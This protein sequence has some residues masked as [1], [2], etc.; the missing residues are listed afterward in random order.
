MSLLPELP[1]VPVG[2]KLINQPDGIEGFWL[3]ALRDVNEISSCIEASDEAIL[4]HL[5]DIRAISNPS[6]DQSLHL[7]FHFSPNDFFKNS[8]LT[9]TYLTKKS[10]LDLED[11]VDG[12]AIYESVGCTIFW[13]AGKNVIESSL[14]RVP[15]SFFRFFDQPQLKAESK[16]EKEK[17]K[18]S[19]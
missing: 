2:L 8:V 15:G 3:S 12:T 9:K 5:T 1:E 6:P 4:K 11:P 18:V 17:I 16:L 13:H 10:S 14:K 7:E 19:W